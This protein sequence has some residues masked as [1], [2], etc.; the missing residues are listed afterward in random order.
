ML[1]DRYRYRI[2]GSRVVFQDLENEGMLTIKITP[3][4]KKVGSDLMYGIINDIETAIIKQELDLTLKGHS[5]IR[6]RHDLE[7]SGKVS[8]K[9]CFL[10]DTV[11]KDS[12]LRFVSME[13][14]TEFHNSKVG[15]V[16]KTTFGKYIFEDCEITRETMFQIPSEHSATFKQNVRVY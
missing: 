5:V 15:Y 4:C 1:P 14:Y 6:V 8:L 3:T 12:E 13:P 7:M 2:E 10:S 11:I 9:S 16:G